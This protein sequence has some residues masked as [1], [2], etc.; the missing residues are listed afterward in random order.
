VFREQVLADGR[1]ARRGPEIGPAPEGAAQSYRYQFVDA[2]AEPGT[3]YR[4]TVWAVTADGLLARAFSTT[5]K[6]AD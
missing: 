1:I 2:A 4:Y 3:Y 6:T 5:L